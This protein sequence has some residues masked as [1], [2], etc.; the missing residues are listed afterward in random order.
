MVAVSGGGGVAGVGEDADM[1]DCRRCL[2]REF[3]ANVPPCIT[4]R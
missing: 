4:R 3:S 1:R 2:K